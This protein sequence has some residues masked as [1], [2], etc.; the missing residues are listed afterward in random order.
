M[1]DVNGELP[2]STALAEAD[3]ASLTELMSRDPL[4]YQRQD[5]DAIVAA[6]RADR[7]RR[8]AAEKAAAEGSGSRKRGPKPDAGLAAVPLDISKLGL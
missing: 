4:S 5:R 3:P 8:E 2:Q 7:A 1:T 6:L